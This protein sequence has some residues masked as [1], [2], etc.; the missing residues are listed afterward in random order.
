MK[1]RMM[2]VKYEIA[3]VKEYH[4][5]PIHI[6]CECKTIPHKRTNHMYL[7]VYIYIC[8]YVYIH[9]SVYIYMQKYE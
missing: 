1:I 2:R 4:L 8:R 6:L 3:F 9:A 5:H 7:Y